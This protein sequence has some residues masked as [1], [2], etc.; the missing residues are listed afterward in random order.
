M[1]HVKHMRSHNIFCS[2]RIKT[3]EIS[4]YECFTRIVSRETL[5]TLLDSARMAIAVYRTVMIKKTLAESVFRENS[6]KTTQ[7]MRIL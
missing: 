3:I 6:N 4:H 2:R 7:K 5:N 1:F